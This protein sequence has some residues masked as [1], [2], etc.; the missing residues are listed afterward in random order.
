MAGEPILTS[1]SEPR[2]SHTHHDRAAPRGPRESYG[3]IGTF[4]QAQRS[5]LHGSSRSSL[6]GFSTHSTSSSGR[7]TPFER[8]PI[9][10]GSPP[11][12]YQSTENVTSYSSIQSS[13]AQQRDIQQHQL[14]QQ[15]QQQQQRPKSPSD[16][17][18][19]HS[20]FGDGHPWYKRVLDK[21]GSL[22]LDNK[23]SVARDHLALGTYIVSILLESECRK[24]NTNC[25]IFSFRTNVPR[26]ATYLSRLC[27]HRNCHHPTLPSQH[28]HPTTIPSPLI[29]LLL[30]K[31]RSAR[32]IRRIS[33]K[34]L[35]LHRLH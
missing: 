12:I 1:M 20:A 4:S 10:A 30:R 13:S 6:G 7:S 18:A 21:Y 16:S 23:G 29:F 17:M 9:V 35:Q 32:N 14:D 27:I 5:S 34:Q 28:C 11:H 2:P 19:S 15:Q 33:I 22:E 26:L 8:A 25:I 31:L 24:H 3:T